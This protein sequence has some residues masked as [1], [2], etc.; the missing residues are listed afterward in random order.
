M[1]AILNFFAT[2]VIGLLTG[3]LG[4]YI[5]FVKLQQKFESHVETCNAKN[6]Q[7]TAFINE[8]RQSMKDHATFQS[9]IDTCEERNEELGETLKEFRDVLRETRDKTIETAGA[10][11]YLKDESVLARSRWHEINA[12]TQRIFEKVG[13]KHE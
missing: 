2:A 1:D 13:F 3:G 5:A 6:V 10:V 9:H 8:F 11:K 7:L 4:C 12:R